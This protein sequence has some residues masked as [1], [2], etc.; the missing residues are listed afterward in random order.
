MCCRFCSPD[1]SIFLNI[2]ISSHVSHITPV[3]LF[4]ATRKT[5]P[6]CIGCVVDDLD[7][8]LD[9]TVHQG[10]AS[11][12]L[13]CLPGGVEAVAMETAVARCVAIGNHDEGT[14]T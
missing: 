4:F 14:G 6:W 11:V 9:L 1:F 13:R 2:Y 12:C 10:H 5:P 3:S 8:L 7:A